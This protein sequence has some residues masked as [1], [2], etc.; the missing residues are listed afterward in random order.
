MRDRVGNLPIPEKVK[1]KHFWGF[2][3]Y[4]FGIFLYRNR[5][6]EASYSILAPFFSLLGMYAESFE[7]YYYLDMEVYAKA[8]FESAKRKFAKYEMVRNA[9]IAF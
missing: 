5:N 6:F 7:K 1:G 4:G 2:F 8:Y 9:S 3:E